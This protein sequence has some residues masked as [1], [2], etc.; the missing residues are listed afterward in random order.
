MG[1]V[2]KSAV[3]ALRAA[4]TGPVFARGDEGLQEEAAGYN[5]ASV[6]DP[7]FVIS[8]ES[9][10]DAVLAVRF[11][12]EHGLP[13]V[14]SATGHGNYRPVTEG[15]LLR[16]HRLQDLTIDDAT[17]TFTIGAGK[18]WRD[19]VGPLKEHGLLAVT[20]SSPSVGAIGLT[21]GGGVGPLSRKLGI[22]ADRILSYR[23]VT[24]AGEL[25]TVTKESHP[26]LFVAL[27]GGKVG[28]G[29][30][31]EATFQAL[32][33]EHVYGGGLMFDTGDIEPAFRAWID[34]TKTVPVEVTTSANIVRFPPEGFGPQLDGKTIL[35][36][37]YAYVDPDASAD[38]LVAKG[39]EWIKP[40]RESAPVYIDLLELL[41]ADELGKIHL[42]P[43]DPL[44]MAVYGHG[45]VD[46]DQSYADVILK[47]AGGGVDVPFVAT[48]TRFWG[49]DGAIWEAGANE[50]NSIAGARQPYHL[51]TIATPVPELHVEAYPKARDALFRD[52]EPH[53]GAETNYNWA[54][55]PDDAMWKKL[56][57]PKVAERLDAVR[58]KYDPN[59]VFFTGH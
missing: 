53:L 38:E 42:D 5:L 54:G 41:P 15:I 58:A 2:P 36:V 30:V 19:I 18:R 8:P 12:N 59:H 49:N 17:Q 50:E 45:L 44:P 6:F 52:L 43:P 31:V 48:E 20:G 35:H 14:I 23:F 11:A 25:V 26:D 9:E 34:W 28:F 51:L 57:S 27:K 56:W 32:P 4:M 16:T 39:E 40:I 1:A 10:D 24:G 29:L 21:M 37:R 3:E 55:S 33:I 47:H 7:E 22:A 46:V 13:I